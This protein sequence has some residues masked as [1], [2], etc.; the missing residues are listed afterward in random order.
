M[1]IRET[2]GG[3]AYLY[4]RTGGGQSLVV[5]A[6]GDTTLDHGATVGLG[7][8]A[9]RLHQFGAEGRTLASGGRP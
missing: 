2:L 7:L 4:V 1:T 3:D 9:H 8:A 5:R 6:E